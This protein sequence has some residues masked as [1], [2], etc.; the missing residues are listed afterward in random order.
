MTRAE[1]NIKW[2]EK[3]CKVPEGKLVGQPVKLL[4]F[5]KDFI[6]K[7]Y[8][9][10]VP[11]RRG[12]LS[13]GRKNGKSGLTTFLLLLHLVGPEARVNSS[14]YSAARSRDQA[15]I[16]FNLAVKIIKMNPDLTNYLQIVESKKTIRCKRLGTE[17]K[18]LAAE[19][20]NLLGLSPSFCI[21]D[22]LGMVQGARDALFEALESA[23]GAQEAP[24][25]LIISTQAPS[26]SDLLSI[27]I[28]D[29]LE[30][31][32]P[33][34]VC[35]LHTSDPELSLTDIENI[36]RANPAIG[37]FQNEVETLKTCEDASRMPSR[38]NSCRNLI[39]NQR[40]SQNKAFISPSLWKE[41]SGPIAD[42]RGKDLYLG[43]DLSSTNDLTSLV[44]VYRETPESKLSVKT[45]TWT[46]QDTLIEKSHNDRVP[47]DLWEQHGHILTCPGKVINNDFIVKK[48]FEISEQANIVNIA[49]DR[50]GFKYFRPSLIQAGF[51]DSWIEKTFL[52]HG[53]GFKDFSPAIGFLE[54]HFLNNDLLHGDNPVLR[55]AFENVKLAHDPSGNRKFIK[56][57]DRMRI[58]PA[59]AMAMAIHIFNYS[60]EQKK[61][62]EPSYLEQDDLLIL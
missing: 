30:A 13:V 40:I 25:S 22:E 31:H 23:S 5:Q 24:L 32:D 62:S 15:S 26:D 42:W 52:P 28:D 7:I 45:W 14:L 4:D 55:M 47:Y 16:I 37:I 39:L 17:Y 12:I 6:I 53:Q 1:R 33:R 57:M 50:W 51:T 61:S 10:K 19:A 54:R 49:F 36:R 38:E 20:K 34:T 3:Y 9:N 8:D 46:P 43:L 29:A 44:A 56:P 27:I 41:C 35:Q 48:L 60:P 18:A 11:T 21:H 2:I 59:V 58:D